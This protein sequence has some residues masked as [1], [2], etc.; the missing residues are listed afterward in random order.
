MEIGD[1]V[2][3]KEDSFLKEYFPGYCEIIETRTIMRELRYSIRTIDF[4]YGSQNITLSYAN[5]IIPIVRIR[6]E[7]L[8]KLL[9][10]I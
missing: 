9:D 7:K 2:I 5:D 3:L 10:E 4:I 8:N 6:N 1:I